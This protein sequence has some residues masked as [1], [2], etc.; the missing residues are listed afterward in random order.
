MARQTLPGWRTWLALPASLLVLN[1]SLT[2]ENVWPTPRIRWGNALSLELALCVLLLAVAYRWAGQLAQRLARRVLPA[3]WV[4]LVAGHYLDVTAPGLYGRDVNLYWDSQHLGNVAAMLAR[5]APW[6][7]SAAVAGAAV[8]AVGMA[9]VLARLAF[10][11]VAAAMERRGVR[12]VLGALAGALVML[13][14]G[15]RLSGRLPVDIAFA[16]PVTPAY[17]RQARYVLAMVGPGAVA[18]QLGP[19]PAFDLGLRGLGGADVLLIFVESYGAVA[20]ET[21]EISAGLSES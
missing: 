21:P 3:I 20:Y 19:S 9:Y 14:A 18:P 17:V 10:G 8:L 15:Q 13:F 6:W 16:D 1:A 2:F 12:L 5:A 11:R 7:L 4:G